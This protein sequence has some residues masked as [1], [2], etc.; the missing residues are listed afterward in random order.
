MCF[1]KVKPDNSAAVARAEEQSRQGDIRTGADN[2]NTAFDQQ[3]TPQFF[4]GAANDYVAAQ[5]PEIDRQ[6]DTAN[7]KVQ[8]GLQ[9]RGILESSSGARQIADLLRAAGSQRTD[10]A[11]AGQ[12]YA[13]DLRG[14][15]EG[16]R[17]SLLSQNLVAADP[18]Q[19]SKIATAAAG[20]IQPRIPTLS[21]G[22]LFANA[23]NTAGNA[24]VYRSQNPNTGQ[25]RFP[26]SNPS[27]S[28]A[29]RG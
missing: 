10:L 14:Q 2:I 29:V 7:R 23:I 12:N 24:M 1:P 21:L 16:Q 13:Q 25:G 11:N 6:Y 9:S 28:Y 4:T 15:V 19:A 18:S 26:W 3:F 17:Q 22:D 27:S 8:L 20:A 5:A